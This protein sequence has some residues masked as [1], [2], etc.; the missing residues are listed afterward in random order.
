MADR[1]NK[2]T[3]SKKAKQSTK[4]LIPSNLSYKYEMNTSTQSVDKKL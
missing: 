1:P 2:Q 4:Y 3:K